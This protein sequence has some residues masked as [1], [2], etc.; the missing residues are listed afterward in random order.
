MFRCGWVCN[1]WNL[2]TNLHQ[3]TRLLQMRLRRRLPKGPGN[4]ILIM[5][6]W[7]EKK[8]MSYLLPWFISD[9][10]QNRESFHAGPSNRALQGGSGET[11]P[12]I[13][14]QDR[15]AQAGSGQVEN[16]ENSIWS[17]LHWGFPGWIWSQFWTQPLDPRALLTTTSNAAPSSGWSTLTR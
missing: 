15:H 16:F 3:S 5:P 11:E 6:F 13:C 12:D 2:F 17:I 10:R 14:S 9:L 8:K 1:C 4:R 7:L